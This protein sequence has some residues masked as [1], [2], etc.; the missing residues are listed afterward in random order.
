[1]FDR[2][3]V[4]WAAASPA[5]Q[6]W[7]RAGGHAAVRA[8]LAERTRWSLWLAVALGVG[9]WSYFA[10]PVEPPSWLGAAAVGLPALAALWGWRRRARG[11]AALFLTSVVVTAA[12]LGFAAAQLRATRAEAPVLETRWGPGL[13]SG[14]VVSAATLPKGLRL[15]LDRV[16]LAG[17]APARTPARV[18]VRVRRR[19]PGDGSARP[20]DFAPGDRVRLRALLFPPPAPSAPGAFDF[21]R[22]AWF[23]R[24][25]AVGIALG[26]PQLVRRAEDR[27]LALWWAGVRQAIAARVRAARD[28]GAGT[29]AAALLTGDRAAIPETALVAMRNSGL[30][31]LLAISGL[32]IGL[33]AGF[34]FFGIRAGLALV[35]GLALCRPIKKWAALAAL[36]GAFAYLLLSGA[37]VPT[38]RAYVMIGLVFLAVLLDRTAMSMR[39]VAWAAALVLLLAPES[40]LGASFQMSFAAVVA[41]IAA[42]ETLA[43]R[44]LRRAGG[45]QRGLWRRA[46]LYLAGIAL[47]TL[48]ASAATSVF[49]IYHFNRLAAYG[50]AA[51]LVAVPLMGFWI[52][53]W[54]LVALALMAPLGFERL[55]LAPMDAGIA[56]MLRVAETVSGWSGAVTLVPAMPAAGLALAVFGGLWLCLWRGRWRRFGLLGVVAALVTIP[57]ARPPDI[58]VTGDAR[59]L[60]VRGAD[61]RYMLSTRRAERFAAEGWLRRAGQDKANPWPRK[62]QSRDGRLRC[63][64]AGCIYRARGHVV[65]LIRDE[66]ALAEDCAMAEV[67]VS[68]EPVRLPCPAARVVVDRIDLW[69]EGGYAIWLEANGIRVESV[70]GNR[71]TRPWVP[72]PRSRR[73]GPRRTSRREHAAAP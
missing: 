52:M 67:V 36:F 64:A 17:I 27:G 68:V 43:P 53:P 70:N 32:H 2:V 6:R 66:R 51:N 14:R 57:L 47:T 23:L 35:P 48:V 72:L 39:L 38:Q 62:G 3:L 9:T 7:L 25:G 19:A 29:I 22:Y 58:L 46:A 1:M 49:A 30:A 15:V 42:Y 63:D 24:L 18:R 59:L 37:T 40:I 34:L 16:T 71:G 54:G 55:A 10:L 31:H 33:V 61:G 13:V 21:Q 20:P 26:R 5:P 28:D 4:R 41:L 12:G 56:L 44:L 69:R 73:G 50:L 8:F 11:T 60:A 65:A 45:Q